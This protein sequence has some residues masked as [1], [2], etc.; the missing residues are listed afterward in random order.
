MVSK[1]VKSSSL[2]TRELLSAPAAAT[3]LL[4][5]HCHLLFPDVP[6]GLPEITQPFLLCFVF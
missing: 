4:P 2:E 5:R 6:N 3:P 1:L